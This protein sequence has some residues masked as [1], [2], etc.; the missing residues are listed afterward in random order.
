MGEAHPRALQHEH[1]VAYDHV[2][3]VP[4]ESRIVARCRDDVDRRPRERGD[5]EQHVPRLLGKPLEPPPEK[6][7]QA[8]GHG[9][10]PAGFRP[11]DGR[12][13]LE[14]V[15]RVA[16]RCPLDSGQLGAAKLDVEAVAQQPVEFGEPKRPQRGLSHDMAEG[17][18]DGP[19]VG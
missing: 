11:A 19:R 1:P 9:N 13:Q 8:F 17:Q 3:R 2:Q 15:E 14:R 10:R 12:G 7:P 16:G 5:V 18:A 4:G 6:L